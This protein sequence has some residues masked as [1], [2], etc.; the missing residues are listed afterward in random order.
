LYV[1][2]DIGSVSVNAVLMDD[3]QNV[4]EDHYRRTRGQPVEVTLAVL[5]DILSRTAAQQIKSVVV[6]GSGGKLL[7]S[8][9]GCECINEIVAQGKATATLYP[10]VRSVIEMGGEDSKLLL[11]EQDAAGVTRV[12]DFAM[13]TICAAG[14][15]S[16]LDQQAARLGVNIEGEFG[17]MA[18][19]A[20]H[21]PR[22]AGRCS[23]FAKTD[24]IHLQQEATP[25][26]EIVAGLCFALARNFRS[27]IAKGKELAK[28]ISFQGGVAFNEGMIR[29]FTEV[30]NLAPGELIIPEHRASVGA[31]GAIQVQLEKGESDG[32]LNIEPLH[33]YLKHRTSDVK[34]HE[35]LVG[36]DYPIRTDAHPVRTTERIPAYLGVDIGS[37]STNVVVIDQEGRVLSRR[38]LMTAG[39]PI[40]AVQRGIAEVGGEVADK[41]EI[42]GAGTTG[43]GRYLIGDVI[44]ADVVKN[45][46][47]AHATGA[48]FSNKEVD[49]IFEIGGQ[50]S[51][52][53][54]LEN[55][56]VVDFTMNKVCA[57]GTGSF[58][59]EQAEKLGIA[60]KGEFSEMALR[61]ETPAHL[62]ERCTVF[63]ESDLN[64][65]Q[66]R[67]VEKVD[68]V[69]GLCYSIVYNYLNKVVEDRKIG[70]VIFFQGGTAYNRGVK[71]AFEKVLGK[72]VTVPPHHD[73]LGAIGVALIARDESSGASQF[74]GFDL[75]K[76]KYE[77]E[78]FQCKDC[79]NLCEVRRVR[80][81]GEAPLHYGSRCGKYDE[82]KKAPKGQHLPQLFKEREQALL[83]TYQKKL[84]KDPGRRTVGIP[85]IAAFFDLYP[86]WKAYFTEL[87]FQVVLSDATNRT[88]VREGMEHIIAE[89][90]FPIKV[91]HGHVAN[92]LQK[93][94]DYLFLP[95]I[96]NL[97]H[98]FKGMERSYACPYIQSLPYLL[99]SAMS[100]Q[101]G[102]A[103]VVA[104]IFHMEL[105]E[106][107]VRQGFRTVARQLGRSARA[108]D[109]ALGQGLAAYRRFQRATEARGREVLA[110]LS[111]DALAMVIVSRPYNGC[112][113][114][115][116]LNLPGKLRELG[117]LAI[118]IDFLPLSEEDISHD[119]PNMYWKYGQKILAAA[120]II[121]RDARLNAV[122]ITNFGC[123]PDSFIAK[124]FSREL[125]GKPYLTIEVDEHSADIGALTRCEA[126][127]DSLKNVRRDVHTG[128]ARASFPQ[129]VLAREKRRRI[130]M[131]YMDDHGEML[132]AAME[133]HGYHAEVLPMADE[134]SITIGR[135]YTSGKECYP[136]ILTT[137]DIV[138]KTREPGFD[139]DG[140][141][142]F[143]PTAK[144]P[145]RFGQYN[146]FHRMV[147][148]DLGL[149]RVPI[150]M[151]DQTKDFAEDLEN[152]GANFRRIA[153]D[154][155][156][157][158]DLMQK[159]L[160][161]VRP[162]ERHPG[163]S[164][165]LYQRLLRRLADAI[166]TGGEADE[167]AR[168]AR[169]EFDAIEVDR[170]KPRPL[171]GIVGEIFVRSN[172]F[173]NNFVIRRVE[174][175]GG[176]AG[177][178]P[179]E[180]WIDYIGWCRK[181]DYKIER[182]LKKLL[183]EKLA[184][185]FQE[186][187]LRRLSKYFEGS[188]DN[189]LYEADT[190]EVLDRGGRYLHEAI[191][192]EAALS[193]G[194]AVE[195]AEHGFSGVINIV[196]FNCIP[197]TIVTALLKRF[198]ED[199]GD[200]PI[201]N[202]VYD[203]DEQVGE[204]TRLEA[205]M[206][207][208]RQYTASTASMAKT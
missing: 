146:K 139:P 53:I 134:Q 103:E 28:P 63:M 61:A 191:R 208:A 206:Y 29:A 99:R 94:V 15:G 23:V 59:E 65:A 166:R 34:R 44:G 142:F 82:V 200:M 162:Y 154:G 11:L 172:A 80:V 38:Y 92:L 174:A 176:E 181:Q 126:F 111:P 46:I 169:A 110:N 194:R 153:W 203:G 130:Y 186:R 159:V 9:L 55:G 183:V 121:A 13:N 157:L 170:S 101:A 36:D 128:R 32:Q 135:N 132:A 115:L 178:P 180:E 42:L 84:P 131:P 109:K 112:D 22:I 47:T 90:C 37:I 87:G 5:E 1:G 51:K 27:N 58:L 14:T 185:S 25:D 68:L 60:I 81:E 152:L 50:D 64:H 78:T 76:R 49:T 145:C 71:A 122:Y 62:G 39:R 144:G 168:Q 20:A 167:I 137:G 141:A 45:E 136:C 41:V 116:N 105:G 95:S 164:D 188:V 100:L 56:A 106:K 102:G 140:S 196:P 52:Y 156:V 33:E 108:S 107:H 129:Y 77:V 171:I 97:E 8:L 124:F 86:M 149:G 143:M 207:Q 79:P 73:V 165:E 155:I 83:N 173:A 31:I 91:A 2:L 70:N 195:Y 74:K 161:H 193:M 147:L 182:E 158:V 151:L 26:Y 57:A 18:K 199:H 125:R 69:A 88:I 127:I 179:L 48:A 16:F 187:A 197:G 93:K 19:R 184:D 189:F 119:F 133:R 17:E 138:K 104:P 150:V 67:G 96:I 12:K 113:P 10:H 85:R 192:G 118:P 35:P 21:P 190:Q 6:T 54:S 120:R 177:M 43:S 98:S 202:L 117:V 160:R 30:L 198:R 148:D 201:L 205:F 123:G 7:S 24:M 66:Q 75:A 72:K 89:T 4:V 114:G 204:A 175:L 40:V 163:E 3:A